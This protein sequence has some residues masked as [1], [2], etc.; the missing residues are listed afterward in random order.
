LQ[1][2]ILVRIKPRKHDPEFIVLPEILEQ[3]AEFIAG[4]QL[5]VSSLTFVFCGDKSSDH[6]GFDP[7]Q[8]VQFKDVSNTFLHLCVANI[9]IA[10]DV[11]LGPQSRAAIFHDHLLFPGIA[12]LPRK[13]IF[14][15]EP[16]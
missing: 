2:P 13:L 16:N 3:V 9:L 10:V 1:T 4:N 11:E 7:K 5:F 12:E 8:L 14:H 15:S 6:C